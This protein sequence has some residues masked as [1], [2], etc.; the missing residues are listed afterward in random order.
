MTAGSSP[1]VRGI[2]VCRGVRCIRDR[3]IPACAGNTIPS[4]QCRQ[5]NPVHP[6]VFGEY[7]PPD[8]MDSV[9]VGSSPRVR[10][11]RCVLLRYCPNGRFIPACAGNTLKRLNPDPSTTVHPRVCG[12]YMTLA[13][14]PTPISGSSPR[15]RG[16][17]SQQEY[18]DRARRFIPACA[19]NTE[20]GAYTS[21]LQAVHPRVC[22]EYRIGFWSVSVPSGSSPRVRGIRLLTVEYEPIHRFIP[23]CAGN[24]GDGA[25]IQALFAVHPRV[26]GEYLC[27]RGQSR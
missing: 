3:F 9:F 17:R 10:G 20:L 7:A 24:T 11:I 19:G 5:R 13:T 16:I 15:V 25:F 18:C 12:E 1:R 22:G 21:P 23:A 8:I 27:F 26:C 14:G 4:R 2:R 6:R